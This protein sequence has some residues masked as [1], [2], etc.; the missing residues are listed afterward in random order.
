MAIAISVFICVICGKIKDGTEG[1]NG[2]EDASNHK[3][4]EGAPREEIPLCESL[5]PFVNFVVKIPWFL[6][7]GCG[8]RPRCVLLIENPSRFGTVY[9]SRELELYRGCQR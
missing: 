7:F 8:Q 5:C 3:G 2:R 4:H 9:S 1:R 6:Y